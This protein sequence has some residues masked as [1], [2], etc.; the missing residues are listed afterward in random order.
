M[1]KT[2]ITSIS[3]VTIGIIII[4]FITVRAFEQSSVQIAKS[5]EMTFTQVSADMSRS[6]ENTSL[7]AIRAFEESAKSIE[8]ISLKTETRDRFT[9]CIDTVMSKSIDAGK[10]IS[11]SE[12]KDICMQV[13][14]INGEL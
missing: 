6:F 10:P 7:G 3:I 13:D 4:F 5:F 11:A 14:R 1:N 8:K 12:A 2:V 9:I